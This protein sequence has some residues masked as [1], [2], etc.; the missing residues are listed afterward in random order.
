[1]ANAKKRCQMAPV[2]LCVMPQLATYQRIVTA[3]RTI[4]SLSQIK[5]PLLAFCPHFNLLEIVICHFG[6]TNSVI[7]AVHLSQAAG[8]LSPSLQTQA[9]LQP[10]N[11]LDGQ[12]T[13]ATGTSTSSGRC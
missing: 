8:T 7:R 2:C 6:T 12:S 11:K 5:T 3:L 1:M 4:L 10:S 9:A 13:K